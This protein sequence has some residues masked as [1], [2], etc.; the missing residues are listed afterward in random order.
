[1]NGS[2]AGRPRPAPRFSPQPATGEGE[3]RERRRAAGSLRSPVGA[4][5]TKR[6]SSARSVAK[7]A[8]AYRSAAPTAANARAVSSWPLAVST[9]WPRPE[10]RAR[11]LREHGADHGDGAGDPHA[12]EARGQRR[13][14]PPAKRNACQRTASSERSS[15]R[16]S[17][18]TLAQ[19]VG[20]V[21]DDREEADQRDDQRSSARCRSRATNT[22][23]G[24]TTGIGTACEPTTQRPQ[25]AAHGRREVHRDRERAPTTIAAAS[26][27]ATSCA[28]TSRSR[29]EHSAVLPQRLGDLGRRGEHEVVDAA[30][31]RRRAPRPRR[32]ASS[33]APAARS[34]VTPSASSARSRSSTT[35][36]PSRAR[37]RGSAMSSSATTRPGRGDSTR[38]GRR[39][40]LPPRRR[41]SRAAPCAARAR[42]PRPATSA[43]ARG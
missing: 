37:G 43:S 7:S 35:S 39:A 22:S 33:D 28:V 40:A 27:P 30:E 5:E 6:R 25:R 20:V 23:S 31:A 41:G 2:L 36:G 32:A 26:P 16:A 19:P 12:G 18:S 1:M 13:R 24:A 14:A 10:L 4:H 34:S 15:L 3:R 38:S 42:A 17:G 29:R 8:T 9:R 21:D 11:P